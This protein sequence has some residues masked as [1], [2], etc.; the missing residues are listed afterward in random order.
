M[1]ALFFLIV[2]LILLFGKIGLLS[3]DAKVIVGIKGMFQKMKETEKKGRKTSRGSGWIGGTIGLVFLILKLTGVI[4][5]AWV[6]VLTP[7]WVPAALAV[8]FLLIVGII[9]LIAVIGL[10]SKESRVVVGI[11][12]MFKKKDQ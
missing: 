1:G 8:L 11:K 12:N 9:L 2:G 5:W 6:W 7:L 4:T 3:E 10:V